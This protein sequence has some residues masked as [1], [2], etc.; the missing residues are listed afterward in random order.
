MVVR[1]PRDALK[2][3]L[4]ARVREPCRVG[5]DLAH[6]RLAK[7]FQ[8]INPRVQARTRGSNLSR[9]GVFEDAH[10]GK[11]ATAHREATAH[12]NLSP[13]ICQVILLDAYAG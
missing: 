11:D 12:R 4:R 9:Y 2:A 5:V 8:V 13:W 10:A 6:A 1:E 7:G 3:P